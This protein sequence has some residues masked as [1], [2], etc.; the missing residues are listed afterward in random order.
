MKRYPLDKFLELGQS[1]PIID[2]RSPGEY[3][4]G[5]LPHSHN[6]PLLSNE[7]RADV[8]TIYKQVNPQAAFKKGLEYIGPKMSGFIDF[9][10]NLHNQEL[11]VHCW[12]G[13]Q[14]SQSVALLLEAYGFKVGVLEGGYKS[15]R[16]AALSFFEQKLPLVVLTGYTGS[17]KTE[18]LHELTTLGEQVVD[19]EGLAHH[20]GSAFGRQA[21]EIQPSSEQFQNELYETFRKM[22]LS[23]RIWVEDESM[24]IGSVNMMPELYHQKNEAP[25]V[26]MD[27]PKDA[28][29]QNLIANYG[30]MDVP[31]LI[32]A[33]KS[34]SKKLG[35][36]EAETAIEHIEN[37]DAEPAARIIL[38]YYDKRYHKAI[39]D[40]RDHFVL[41]LQIDSRDPKELAGEILRRLE[42]GG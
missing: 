29:I 21:S 22:D 41:H 24:R 23:K 15:Y 18:V 37:G 19:L 11:L 27:I 3:E 5:R 36:K 35:L 34:I 16:T 20:Q 26:F 31:K 38:K 42:V 13:G 10:E 30:Q 17:R 8:G 1:Q 2:V 32:K 7:E 12:R 4:L 25:C 40:K 39:E 28:R 6:M 14:R 9:A 33:T